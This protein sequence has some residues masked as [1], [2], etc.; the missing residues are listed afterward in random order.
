[1][2]IVLAFCSGT[3][4]S[5]DQPTRSSLIPTLVPREDLM[6]AISLQSTV[7]NGVAFIGP[8]LAGI[9]LGFFTNL[10]QHLSLRENLAAYAGN[11]FLNGISF[12]GVLVVLYLLHVSAE[13]TRQ[14]SNL[15]VPMLEA[16]RE[17]LIFVGKDP[18]LPWILSGYA[19]LLFFGPS[20]SLIL[21]IFAT[22]A[23]HLQALQLGLLFSASGLGVLL[24]A[25]LIASLGD[26]QQK[27]IL[28]LLSFIIWTA[29]FLI[30]GVSKNLWLSMVMLV[31][32]GIG[33]NGVGATTITLL[34]TRVPPNMRG[35]VMSLN[36]LCIMGIRPLGDFPASGLI[37]LIGGPF[38]VTIC[39]S[40]VGIYT[41]YI[42][43][44]RP[45]IRTIQ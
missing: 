7:F 10:A 13:A 31:F 5:F 4:L 24:G 6:N 3:V 37:A 45:I 9:F 34:Q 32:L 12:L 14:S 33:Q 27:G 21:P 11:F 23:L 2:V 26:F 30:F 44:E 15:R 41:L 35:R 16:V 28:L 1:M 18:A 42:L 29:A 39:A 17:S 40:I 25:L 36:A 8:T 20:T 22:Q 43:L 38:T 19:A